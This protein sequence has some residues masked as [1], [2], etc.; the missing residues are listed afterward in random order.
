MGDI[1]N[2]AWKLR[3][4]SSMQLLIIIHQSF[5]S[6]EALTLENCE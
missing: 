3:E 6:R 5:V 1:N 4:A 2:E